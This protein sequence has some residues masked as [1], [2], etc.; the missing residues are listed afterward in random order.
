MARA[1]SEVKK[2]MA[3]SID[4]T[5]GSPAKLLVQFAI[6][7]L[8]GNVFQQLYTLVDRVI[9]GQFVGV[10]QVLRFLLNGAGDS[11]YALIN[12]IVE[13]LARIGFAVLLT[14]IPFIGMWGIWLTTGPTWL[15]TAGF[16]FWRYKGGAWMTKS[17]VRA[18]NLMDERSV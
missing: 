9:V 8:I 16:A 7:I 3:K 13:I 15:V 2:C 1:E 17:L 10:V 4:M 6:P 12:G 5:K 18:A 14:A 11:I